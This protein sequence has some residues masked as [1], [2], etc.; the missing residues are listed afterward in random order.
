MA[1]S[2]HFQLAPRL[3]KDQTYTS[4]PLWNFI[5]CYRANFIFLPLSSKFN[6][7]CRDR[8]NDIQIQLGLTE[9]LLQY[10]HHTFYPCHFVKEYHVNISNKSYAQYSDPYSPTYAK[11]LNLNCHVRKGFTLKTFQNQN[12]TV[13]LHLATQSV[14]DFIKFLAVLSMKK[15]WTDGGTSP[16]IC[17]HVV[18]FIQNLK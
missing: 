8:R 12:Q 7:Y 5:A 4:T 1:L 11:F 16:P 10:R 17:I 9:S 15:R 13:I 6:I 14:T 2:S 3:K 18:I